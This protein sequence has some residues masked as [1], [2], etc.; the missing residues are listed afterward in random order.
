MSAFVPG[1]ADDALCPRLVL[2]GTPDARRDLAVSVGAGRD[3][4]LAPLAVEAIHGLRGPGVAVVCGPSP[5]ARLDAMTS[6]LRVQGFEVLTVGAPGVREAVAAHLERFRR[7][8]SG[9]LELEV[10]R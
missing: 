7:H 4:V 3:E 2:I 8:R 9:Q 10:P 1:A 6:L 5:W